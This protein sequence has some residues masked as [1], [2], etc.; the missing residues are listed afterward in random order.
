MGG[1]EKVGD[2][3]GLGAYFFFIWAVALASMEWWV[4]LAS[5]ERVWL[6]LFHQIGCGCRCFHWHRLLWLSLHGRGCGCRCFHSYWRAC[7]CF[8]WS[9]FGV[10]VFTVLGALWVLLSSMGRV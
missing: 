3:I 1:V 10:I 4:S 5:L 2:V 8:D 6:P 9:S 7:H